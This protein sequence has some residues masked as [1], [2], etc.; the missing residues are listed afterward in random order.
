M[1]SRRLTCRKSS[2]A[3][4][5]V[6]LR[7]STARPPTT[8]RRRGCRVCMLRA[9]TDAAV[10]L[11]RPGSQRTPPVRRRRLAGLICLPIRSRRWGS[12]R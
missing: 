5:S 9:L 2:R 8:G 7:A 3:R 11:N 6:T 1:L 4:A 10:G 12:I